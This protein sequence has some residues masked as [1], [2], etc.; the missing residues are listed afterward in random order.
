MKTRGSKFILTAVAL[1]VM[2]L[3]GASPAEAEVK[4]DDVQISVRWRGE[5]GDHRSPYHHWGPRRPRR[6]R[7][8]GPH[9]PWGFHGRPGRHGPP[10]PPPPHHRRHEWR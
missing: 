10:P 7:H 6:H 3:S 9:G 4:L 5:R 2:G 1:S 8:G